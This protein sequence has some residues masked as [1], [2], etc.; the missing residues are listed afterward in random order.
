MKW[1]PEMFDKQN[2]I[3]LFRISNNNNIAEAKSIISDDIIYSLEEINKQ[4]VEKNISTVFNL[5]RSTESYFYAISQSSK[6]AINSTN[7][8]SK[9]LSLISEDLLVNLNISV[10]FSGTVEFYLIPEDMEWDFDDLDIENFIQYE[11][12]I[13]TLNKKGFFHV[14]TGIPLVVHELNIGEKENH[15]TE[16]SKNNN[17]TVS[18]SPEPRL[19][20][21][22]IITLS[23]S[24]RLKQI[25]TVKPFTESDK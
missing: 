8:L 11:N 22:K 24:E 17:E 15:L 6:D 23:R 3:S 2:I 5:D 7:I 9:V 21:E 19:S 13:F 25:S 16:I 20:E 18:P 1:N 10:S 12:D 4:I 14:E